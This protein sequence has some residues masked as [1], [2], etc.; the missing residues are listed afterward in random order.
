[1]RRAAAGWV[2]GL[3]LVMLTRPAIGQAQAPDDGI[4]RRVQDAGFTFHGEMPGLYASAPPAKTAF[5]T[6]VV[7]MA[8]PVDT[9]EQAK[10]GALVWHIE[11]GNLD[12]IAPPAGFGDEVIWEHFGIPN[13]SGLILCTIN[14][15]DLDTLDGRLT[16]ALVF[17]SETNEFSEIKLPDA[18]RIWPSTHTDHGLVAG[19][20]HPRNK[21]SVAFAWTAVD[22]YIALPG[23][24]GKTAAA[25]GGNNKGTLV[26]TLNARGG[27]RPILWPKPDEP[28]AER[29]PI[30]LDPPAGHRQAEAT[31]IN[32]AGDVLVSSIEHKL[33]NG[34]ALHS[35]S[36]PYLWNREAG[37]T[38]LQCP[39]HDS[40]Y[41][42]AISNAGQVLLKGVDINET[43]QSTF[44]YYLV[45]QGKSHALP[46]YP[47]ADHTDYRHLSADGLIV[48][49]AV[50]SAKDRPIERAVVSFVLSFKTADE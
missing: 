22:G 9:A 36:T 30:A 27:K 32:D 42:H 43:G 47:G 21:S 44:H 40:V 19:W 2:I 33:V 41:P 8:R 4:A 38:K 3:L 11:S 48:G 37:Y 50:F 31:A 28:G 12:V 25:R 14:L 5:G 7:G 17:N 10:P 49:T 15:P 23:V 16:R 35:L 26:G 34:T 1:M 46:T 18:F 6:I 39:E 13:A 24:D 29:K 20:Y 45:D